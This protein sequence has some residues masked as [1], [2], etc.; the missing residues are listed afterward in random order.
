MEIIP[1]G[2]VCCDE[3]LG[4]V[5][6]LAAVGHRNDEAVV[7]QDKVLVLEE[8]PVDAAKHFPFDVSYR[9]THQVVP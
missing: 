6:V 3:E 8:V 1:R 2:L 9:V 4:A 7:L 5:G